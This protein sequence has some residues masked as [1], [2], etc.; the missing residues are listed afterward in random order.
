MKKLT[1]TQA[2]LIWAA[3]FNYET[4]VQ[5]TDTE[6]GKMATAGSMVF[7]P[8]FIAL[9][10]YSY[11][12]YFI[13]ENV[14]VAI[15]G[16]IVSAI[17]LFIIDRSIM[18]YGRPGSFSLGL[19]GRLMLAVTVG[20]LLAEPLIL[21]IFDDSIQE[22]Q[23]TELSAAKENT[24]ISYEESISVLQEELS[25]SRQHLSSLQEAYTAEMDGT[26]GS[27]IRNQGPIFQ[28]KYQ[29]YQDY[30]KIYEENQVTTRAEIAE[31]QTQKAEA[32][33]L[34]EKNNANGLIGRMRA[35]SSL[36][37]KEPIVHWTTWML[38]IFFTLIELLP[39]LIKISPAGDRG[40]Y[41][42]LV[43]MNDDEKKQIFEMSSKERLE[44]KQ[45]EEKLR[46]TQAFAEL[47][48]Q[49]TQI[50]AANKAKDSIF[51]MAKLQELTE[52]KIDFDERA[53]STI[54]DEDLLN[55]ILAKFNQIHNGFM[56]TINQLIIKS[57]SNFSTD[58][59]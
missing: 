59:G 9:F 21:K 26:G 15:V 5:C 49:E 33:D 36:G 58:K 23:F 24:A 6:R 42:E 41:Y 19:L 2:L 43:D 7:I 3:G 38:R 48:Q 51:L 55:E 40:L 20:F 52:K 57:N 14:T 53:M 56:D 37:E 18:A 47:C 8:A 13:F 1:K 46:L 50:I 27:K 22:Q 34:V 45:Q 35:L 28:Q 39:L 25:E 11:G 10:S 54:M 17:V 32:M 16:G 30:Q 31:I 44:F 4:A 29:D 12:F